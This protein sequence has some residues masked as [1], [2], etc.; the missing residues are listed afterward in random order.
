MFIKTEDQ[1]HACKLLN[2]HKHVMMYG[3]S[4]SGKTT[5]GVRNLILRAYKTSSRHLLCRFR[6][7]H[8]KTSLAHDTVPK[9]LRMCFDQGKY[10]PRWNKSD[11]YMD[12]KR[13]FNSTSKKNQGQKKRKLQHFSDV[14][15]NTK[16]DNQGCSYKP[17]TS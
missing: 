12:I 2:E 8:A 4:R 15:Y 7:N 13:G 14:F 10:T 6:F 5:I 17:T 1:V 9:V 16:K 11:W 3:G